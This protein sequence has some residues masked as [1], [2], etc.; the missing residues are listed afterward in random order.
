MRSSFTT[1]RAV[2]VIIKSSQAEWK[3]G[4]E[5]G[6]KQGASLSD[7]KLASRNYSA[8]FRDGHRRG[9][10]ELLG[11]P[12]PSIPYV[13]VTCQPPKEIALEQTDRGDHLGNQYAEDGK[14]ELSVEALS[15]C[16]P[17]FAKAYIRA[18]SK[19]TDEIRAEDAPYDNRRWGY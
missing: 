15:A 7:Q 12:I 1:K 11:K 2:D 4:Y 16:H 13:T 17:S 18:F 14:E 8:S 9:R 19:A 5:M 10:D 6:R 3:L